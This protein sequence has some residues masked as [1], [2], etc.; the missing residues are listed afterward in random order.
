MLRGIVRDSCKYALRRHCC[1]V[2]D[3]Y[4]LTAMGNRLIGKLSKNARYAAV[5]T[6]FRAANLICGL[7]NR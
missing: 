6:F 5:L 3:S 4:Q 2:P 1:P 7:A